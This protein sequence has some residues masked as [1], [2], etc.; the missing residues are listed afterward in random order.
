MTNFDRRR[1]RERGEEQSM[2]IMALKPVEE[3]FQSS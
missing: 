3:A 1:E 2:K